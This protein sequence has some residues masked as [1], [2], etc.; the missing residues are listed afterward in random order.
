IMK[1]L[2]LAVLVILSM[3]LVFADC[4][5]MI[6]FYSTSCHACG[7]T[8][9]VLEELEQEYEVIVDKR[10]LHEVG[11]VNLFQAYLN[12]YNVPGDKWGYT[13]TI[14]VNDVYFV[15]YTPELKNLLIEQINKC[16]GGE[17]VCP[18]NQTL[19]DLYGAAPFPETEH[20]SG[21]NATHTT[22][23]TPQN[24]ELTIPAIISAALIDSINPCAFAVMIFLLSYLISIGSKKRVLKV[25]TFYIITV[26]ITYF[27]AGLGLFL[28]VQSTNMS[29]LV[30]KVSAFI[31]IIAGL[32]NVKDFFWYGKGI[33]LAIPQEAKPS[34]N[35]WTKKASI[36]A[37]IVLGFL[38]S[39]FELPCTGG[40]YLAIL[41]L[42]S[43]NLTKS[44]AILPLMLYNFIFV[45]PLIILMGLVYFGVSSEKLE[46]WRMKKR[47]YMKLVS[48]LFM[49][50]LG[51]LM[52]GGL[53]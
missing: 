1:K 27:L 15:G 4:T 22:T 21:Y 11:N 28:A 5:H 35:K 19:A 45:V 3:Q 2:F 52:L 38:V 50:L 37:A 36:P 26:F 9:P 18:F 24:I 47:N 8:S 30:Y 41:G 34:I 29:A 13:P 25:G 39:M 46:K 40:V 43:N 10:E 51:V 44:Q 31:A 17:C 32:L 14:F 23:T 49:I 16:E 48:G 20:G 7:L 42:L 6:Y 12:I 53:I 33:T